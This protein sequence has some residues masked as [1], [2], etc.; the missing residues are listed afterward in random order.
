MREINYFWP[1]L[2]SSW[3][4]YNYQL[5]VTLGGEIDPRTGMVMNLV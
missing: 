3:A 5:E 1:L 4:Y 2:H